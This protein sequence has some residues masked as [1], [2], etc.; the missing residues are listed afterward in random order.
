[1]VTI[2]LVVIFL[3]PHFSFPYLTRL[4]ITLMSFKTY[5]YIVFIFVFFYCCCS[6]T[7]C[8]LQYKELKQMFFCYILQP[9]LETIKKKLSQLFGYVCFHQCTLAYFFYGLLSSIFFFL[10]ILG[11]VSCYSS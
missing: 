9:L 6:T 4:V 10:M 11:F 5:S 8:L 1:M 2:S 7:A 3:L